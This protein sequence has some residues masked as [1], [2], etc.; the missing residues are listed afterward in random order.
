M[1]YS[2]FTEQQCSAASLPLSLSHFSNPL[3]GAVHLQ[4]SACVPAWP[5]PPPTLVAPRSLASPLL[6]WLFIPAH[7]RST[8]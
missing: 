3:L 4:P 5:A 1:N 2:R 7:S 6:M 8:S